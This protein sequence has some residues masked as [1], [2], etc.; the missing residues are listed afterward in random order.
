MD[1]S[2]SREESE[3]RGTIIS[4]INYIIF[5]HL[6]FDCIANKFR[7]RR[8]LVKRN[9]REIKIRQMGVFVLKMNYS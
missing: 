6:L 1:P 9:N 3:G 4:G 2:G 7:L 8:I 5:L